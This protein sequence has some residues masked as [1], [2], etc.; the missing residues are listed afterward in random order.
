MAIE[1]HRL[2]APTYTGGLPATHDFANDPAS[3][4][5]PG[6]GVPAPADGMKSGGPNDGV[7]F[8]AFGEDATANDVNRVSK[9]LAENTDFL[10]NVIHRDLATPV[11]VT[12]LASG[13]GI[14]SFVIT[15][16]VYVGDSVSYDDNY[17]RL[18]LVPLLDDN[19]APIIIETS[20]SVFEAVR[21]TEIHDGAHTTVVGNGFH[22]NP[23]IEIAPALPAAY[24]YGYVYYA[25]NNLK[26]QHEGV[27][28]RTSFDQRGVSLLLASLVSS[29]VTDTTMPNWK[30]GT[31]NPYTSLRLQMTKVLNEL[32]ADE[33]SDRIGS[34]EYVGSN[35]TLTDSVSIFAHLKEL[36]DFI[37]AMLNT[38][39]N[40]WNGAE[41]R[42]H[43]RITELGADL[44]G[45]EADAE[46]AR[47]T[48]PTATA[49]VN[50][51]TLLWE[52]TFPGATEKFRIYLKNTTTH[53]SFGWYLTSNAYWD[54][55][56]S[57]WQYDA[58]GFAYQ[59][60]ISPERVWLFQANS[61]T[62][63]APFS[64]WA[65]NLNLF[66]G[67]INTG[68]GTRRGYGISGENTYV[69]FKDDG[70]NTDILNPPSTYASRNKLF[71]KNT[72]KVWASVLTV[73]SP[74]DVRDGFNVASVSWTSSTV[75]RIT[76][77]QP[78]RD[79]LYF[80]VPSLLSSSL[81]WVPKIRVQDTDWIEIS[82][83]DIS[84]HGLAV[85]EGQTDLVIGVMVMGE[86]ASV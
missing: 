13:G 38:R 58:A 9:A 50:T 75:L 1:F 8:V 86:Q 45:A 17:H 30:D 18:R 19:G 37:D 57:G 60:Q 22:T 6:A 73:N 10:D 49:A 5:P 46:L 69:E 3:N 42:I 59:I 83:Y 72:P 28:S 25:R 62:E 34:D 21:I 52:F 12:G 82:A 53:D 4:S 47:I 65:E 61:T 78:M 51:Y 84:T 85:L 36:V 16:D 54:E 27:F 31:T 81:D 77:A 23:T 74:P 20:P 44:V 70:V 48:T 63:T 40:T 79:N 2:V 80:A 14:S 66:Q 32:V 11:I 67:L 56:N 43:K 33:G 41:Q 76:F 35:L 55:A 68:G 71:G 24:N 64:S 7:Y 29:I 39:T 26:T 15:G